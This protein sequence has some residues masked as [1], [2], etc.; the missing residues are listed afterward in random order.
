[1]PVRQVLIEARI[2]EAGDGFSKSLGVRFG[3][4]RTTGS[5]SFGFG[6]L[7]V[8]T[9]QVTTIPTT[10]SDQGVF[11]LSLFNS[12]ATR[13]LNREISANESDGKVKTIASPK[14]LT[15]DQ[16]EAKI[17]DGRTIPYNK[18]DQA[19]NTTTEF[20][21]ALL[22][23]KVTP[24]I[25]PDGDVIMK[26]QIKKDTAELNETTGELTSIVKK[27]VDTQVLVENGGTIVIG[28]IYTLSD[29]K[30]LEKVPGLGDLPVLGNLFKSTGYSTSK[31]EMLVF[32]TPRLLSEQSTALVR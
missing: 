11:A 26:L 5:A 14:I 9:T 23:L 13:L 15:A 16:R 7:G 1:V 3:G 17:E 18:V 29:T 30:S 8:G 32:I 25:T 10:D 27:A 28:G 31:T 4:R 22:S 19:G 2:V 20:V 6:T 24:Q 21:D 12:G